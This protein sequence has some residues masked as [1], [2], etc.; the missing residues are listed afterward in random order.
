MNYRHAYHAGNFADVHKHA[1]LTLLLAHLRAKDSAFHVLDCHAGVGLYDLQAPE[2]G[3]T[4]EFR[5]GVARLWD[6]APPDPA[7]ADYL[8]AVAAINPEGPPR[9]YPGSPWLIRQA[10]RPDDRLTCVELHPDDAARLRAHFGGDRQV[11][12]RQ[13]DAY[14]ALKA[15]LPPRQRRGLVLLDP[16][17]EA[18]EEAQRLISGLTEALRRWPTGIY[19]VWY[20]IKAVAEAARFTAELAQCGR[21]CLTSE[22][23]QGS[24]EDVTRLNGSGLALINPPWRLD[25]QL[26]PLLPLLHDRLGCRGKTSVRWLARE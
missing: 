20:P 9:F 25:R 14:R 15:L 22:L 12:V 26:T 2:P 18:A 19:A 23:M 4:G 8:A 5:D 24:G 21:P 11:S 7:L 1:T 10:L 17:Y 3:K 13:E 16:P 6:V